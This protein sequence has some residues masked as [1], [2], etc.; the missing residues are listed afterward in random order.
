MNIVHYNNE[1]IMDFYFVICGSLAILSIFNVFENSLKVLH[2]N[3]FFVFSFSIV[4]MIFSLIGNLYLGEIAINLNIFLYGLVLIWSLVTQTKLKNIVY[5]FIIASITIACFIVH[6]LVGLSAYDYLY[7]LPIAYFALFIGF[8]FAFCIYN[9]KIVFAGLTLGAILFEVFNFVSVDMEY[10]LGSMFLLEFV[11]VGTLSYCF[12]Y[13]VKRRIM[14]Y[15]RNY[16]LKKNK[17]A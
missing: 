1:V 14:V 6:N 12:T 4:S 3:R 10:V 2:L 15:K 5:I 7:V 11:I 9:L 17:I 8:I 13:V 16:S